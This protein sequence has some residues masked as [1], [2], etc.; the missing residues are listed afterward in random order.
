MDW[1]TLTLV[2]ISFCCPHLRETFF[3][4]SKKVYE[5]AI[6]AFKIAQIYLDFQLQRAKS[7]LQPRVIELPDWSVAVCNMAFRFWYPFAP[8]VLIAKNFVDDEPQTDIQERFQLWVFLTF[9]ED[10]E[11]Q[12]FFISGACPLFEQKHV[13]ILLTTKQSKHEIRITPESSNYT[14]NDNQESFFFNSI[15]L[16]F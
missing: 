14:I 10:Q 12:R 11:K 2:G 7:W 15:I 3:K 8:L 13:Y 1:C 9:E 6:T 4:Y 5:V 16:P